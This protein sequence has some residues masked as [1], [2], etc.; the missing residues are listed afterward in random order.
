MPIGLFDIRD[1]EPVFAPDEI[2]LGRQ[3]CEA[4]GLQ[5]ITSPQNRATPLARYV[6]GLH[7]RFKR[8]VQTGQMI[9]AIRAGYCTIVR[10]GAPEMSV[11]RH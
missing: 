1:R 8:A 4:E 2:E 11:A 6:E 10:K 7:K 5:Y 9:E 3:K